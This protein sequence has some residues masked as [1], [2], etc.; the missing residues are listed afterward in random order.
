MRVVSLCFVLF[1]ALVNAQSYTSEANLARLQKLTNN[2]T[3]VIEFDT[4]K[5]TRFL[6]VASSGQQ[7]AYGIIGFFTV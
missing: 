4:Q 7:R 6:N 1:V 3:K 2:G 5:Y